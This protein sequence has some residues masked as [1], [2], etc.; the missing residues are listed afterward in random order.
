MCS[1]IQTGKRTDRRA[2]RDTTLPS[3]ERSETGERLRVEIVNAARF[4]PFVNCG[5][6]PASRCRTSGGS[7]LGGHRPLQIV[8][9][10]LPKFSR[11]LDTLWS[12]DSQRN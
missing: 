10:P 11:T 7:T 2:D 4:G 12:I 5:P 6:R 1:R 8:A 3:S 9:S